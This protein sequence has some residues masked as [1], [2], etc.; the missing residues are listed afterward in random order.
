MLK[1]KVLPLMRARHHSLQLVHSRIELILYR[2][3]LTA[4]ILSALMLAWVPLDL[5]FL[6][7]NDVKGVVFA[8]VIASLTLGCMIFYKP[9]SLTPALAARLM[10]VMLTIPLVFFFYVNSTLVTITWSKDIQ[11]IKSSY[12]HFPI[13]IAMMLSLF[14]LTAV[15]GIAFSMGITTVTIFSLLI[16]TSPDFML[17]D[18]GTIWIQLVVTALS[19]VAAMSQLHFMS[20][21][22]EF[23]TRDDMTKCLKRDFGMTLLDTLLA[24]HARK[25]HPLTIFFID[26]DHFKRVNDTFG[27]DIG[28]QVLFNAAEAMRTALR[29]Q[30]SVIRWGGEEFLVILPDTAMK[31]VGPIL[32]R[33]EING[34]GQLPDG[35]IQTGSMGI[36]EVIE[37]LTGTSSELVK[38]ADD[39]MY[40]AKRGGGNAIVT[41]TSRSPLVPALGLTPN[42]ETIP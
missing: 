5:T 28:D 24:T 15:E 30:D 21:F 13:L 32:E 18:L 9:R 31:D 10:A 22:I 29:K 20:G 17:V 38:L 25:K 3:R 7:W 39:R 37:D 34:F 40:K 42:S 6:A 14:P 33:L 41:K 26:L 16:H 19:V 36:A 4:L 27:H 35:E 12:A 2:V 11:F 1:T 8:R 23:S